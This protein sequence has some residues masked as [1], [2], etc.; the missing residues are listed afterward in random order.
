MKCERCGFESSREYIR[1]PMCNKINLAIARVYYVTVFLIVVLSG[2]FIVTL[3]S[4]VSI[5]TAVLLS[6]CIISLN[7]I[8]HSSSTISDIVFYLIGLLFVSV[9]YFAM[10]INTDVMFSFKGIVTVLCG[11]CLVKLVHSFSARFEVKMHGVQ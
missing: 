3:G 7:R 10:S 9:C 1:C 4:L 11:L 6:R 8:R 5:V 2:S